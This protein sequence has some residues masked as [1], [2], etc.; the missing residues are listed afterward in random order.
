VVE[1][2]GHATAVRVEI[3]PVSAGPTVEHEAIA[4]ECVDDGTSSE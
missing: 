3:V 4:N 2:D 1:R